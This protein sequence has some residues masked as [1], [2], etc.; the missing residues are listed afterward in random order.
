MI[1]I[2]QQRKAFGLAQLVILK[3][4]F[5]KIEYQY[6]LINKMEFGEFFSA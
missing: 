3:K 6:F 5:D 4:S 1:Y 2:N